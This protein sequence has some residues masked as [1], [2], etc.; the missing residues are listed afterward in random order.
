MTRTDAHSPANLV[1]EDYDHVETYDSRIGE[2]LA[3]GGK[4][5]D[6]VMYL[7]QRLGELR[8]LVAS[9]P[10]DRGL[11]QCHHCGAHIR[12]GAVLRHT[13]TGQHIAVGETCLDNRFERATVEFQALRKAAQ[14]DREQQR[15]RK[16]KEEFVA[17]NEDLAWLNGTDEDVPQCV[18]WSEYVWDIRRKFQAYAD[19]SENQVAA[20][21]RTVERSEAQAAEKAKSE[22]TWI[23]APAEG[24]QEIT[25]KVLAI[26]DY[27]DQYNYGATIWKMLVQVGPDSGAWKLWTTIPAKIVNEVERGDMVTIKVTVVHSDD[28]PTFAKGKRPTVVAPK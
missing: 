3:L 20:I 22:P 15:I 23:A 16:A 5:S 19:L 12:Y 13:P 21:R 6:H 4:V 8:K 27:E 9:S 25:G 24:R 7:I 10:L 18:R 2:S 1:T 11:E 14:L 26:K 28:D 17:A